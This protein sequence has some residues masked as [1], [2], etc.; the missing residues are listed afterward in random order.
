MTYYLKSG[1]SFRVSS[2]EAMDLHET[3]PVGNYVIK[4]DIMGNLFLEAIDG[5]EISGKIY[6]NTLRHTDR[7]LQTFRDRAAST[8]VMLTGEKGSGKTLLAKNLAY[9][10]AKEGIPTIVINQ[11]WCGDAFNSLIQSIEQPCMILFDEY[12]KVYDREQQ[13]KMLTLLDGVFPSKKLFVL[14]CNDKWRVDAHMRNRPGRIFYMLD[15]NGLD[16][17]FICEYCEDRLKDKQHIERLVQIAGTFDQFNFDMLKAVVEEMNRYGE[18]PQEAM[19]M[20]NAKPEFSGASEYDVGLFVNGEQI[21]DNL[22]DDNKTWSGNPLQ[23]DIA[24]GYYQEYT[25][26]DGSKDTRWVRVEF[27]PG[28]LKKIDSNGS[29]FTFVGADS[30][31]LVLTKKPPK[32]HNWHSAF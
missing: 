31:K 19:A 30:A 5:F 16:A 10:A 13:E 6:G 11:P 28:D 14:T 18:S 4:Q 9:T 20:L 21:P 15:F 26:T 8:G 7:I 1:N 17:E 2:K 3:L 23:K 29:V 24:F 22:M 25:E 27:T 32:Y 12:E